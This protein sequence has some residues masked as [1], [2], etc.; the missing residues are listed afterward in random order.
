MFLVLGSI[1]DRVNSFL[2]ISLVSMLT[3]GKV[4]VLI[5]G[6]NITPEMEKEGYI[7]QKAL[8][9]RCLVL[10]LVGCLLISGVITNTVMK[11]VYNLM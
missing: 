10:F 8:Y 3:L 1:F 11:I 7:S 5:D 6:E 2:S 9:I 4:K